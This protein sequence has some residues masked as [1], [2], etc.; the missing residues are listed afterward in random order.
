MPAFCHS[1]ESGNPERVFIKIRKNWIPVSTGMTFCGFSE[2]AASGGGSSQHK[3]RPPLPL[4]IKEG[5]RKPP[6][7]ALLGVRKGE[8]GRVFDCG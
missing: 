1:H 7:P 6:D 4:L 2:A 8:V 5:I 3:E